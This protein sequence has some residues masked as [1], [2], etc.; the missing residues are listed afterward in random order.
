MEHS[1]HWNSSQETG[2]GGAEGPEAERITGK[3]YPETN[4]VHF[5]F[6]AEG[7]NRFKEVFCESLSRE[8]MYK[9]TGRVF[10]SKKLIGL[11]CATK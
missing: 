4:L 3:S 10:F 9:Q 6:P 7:F 2:R 8:C 1:N 5:K 11:K